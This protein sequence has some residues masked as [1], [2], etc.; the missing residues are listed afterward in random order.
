M[1]AWFRKEREWRRDH[2]AAFS[3]VT[4][5]EA[6][7]L[8]RFQHQAIAAVAP[9]VSAEHFKRVSMD[10]GDGEYLVAPIGTNGSELYIYPNEASIFG[11]KPNAWF[12]EWDY[13]TPDQLLQALVQ[14]CAKRAA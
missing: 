5:K 9:F 3:F 7:G 4:V 2:I 6:D 12:E 1:F 11:A 10:K 14:E 13:R 8:T